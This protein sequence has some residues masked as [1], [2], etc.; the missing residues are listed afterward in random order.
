MKHYIRYYIRAGIFI[1]LLL[2]AKLVEAQGTV[3]VQQGTAVRISGGASVVLEDMNLVNNGTLVQTNG[4]GTLRLSGQQTVFF[5]GTGNLVLDKLM[6]NRQPGSQFFLQ[7]NFS[8]L[9]E[10]HFKGGLLDLR[11]H[12]IDLGN[13]GILLDEHESSRAFSSGSGFIQ[14][15]R[16]IDA[17]ATVNAGNLGA[18][19]SSSSPLGATVV[20]RGHQSF[21]MQPNNASIQRYYNISSANEGSTMLRFYFFTAEL[22]GTQE[23]NLSVWKKPEAGSWTN[24]G[25][26]QRSLTEHWVQKS[27]V[28]EFSQWTL[29]E[30]KQPLLISC[31]QPVVVTNDAG[32]CDATLLLSSLGVTASGDPAPK[33]L[34]KIGN[35]ELNGSHR[36]PAGITTVTAIASNGV[37]PDVSCNFTVEVRD[38]EKPVVSGTA[39]VAVCASGGTLSIPAIAATDNC[40]VA[41]ISYVVSGATVRTG[42]GAD[43]TGHFNAGISHITWTVTDKTG[44]SSKFTTK[45]ELRSGLKVVIPD[46]ILLSQGTAPNTVYLGYSP[47][48]S[49]TLYALP[50]G[51]TAPFTYLWSNGAKTPYITVNPLATTTYSVTIT[52]AAGCTGTATREIHVIDVRCGSKLEKVMICKPRPNGSPLELCISAEAVADHLKQGAALGSCGYLT[53]NNRPLAE[54]ESQATALQVKASPNPSAQDFALQFETEIK[55]LIQLFVL[56]AAG[57]ILET[58]QAIQPGS[59]VRIGAGYRSGVYF[60]VVRQAGQSVTVKLIKQH[61]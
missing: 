59:I 6:L 5:S 3:Q 56:D 49:A 53:V 9:G 8:I 32:T 10:L 27:D 52:D 43:A 50:T 51:G 11:D 45:V 57:R 22:N 46:A 36:F 26:D 1:C 12:A 61:D 35:T 39:S 13:T 60:A 48:S 42:T 47:A 16:D 41:S 25:Y 29:A 2:S 34:Y 15:T 14:A 20:R 58:K 19:I 37:Q 38:N 44:N 40:D 30:N 18:V 23:S 33:L 31:P 7:R 55:D 24:L 17:G 54:P 21:F 28:R 4:D